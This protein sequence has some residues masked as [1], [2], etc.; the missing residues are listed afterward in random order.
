MLTYTEPFR[1]GQGRA[2]QAF[3]KYDAVSTHKMREIAGQENVPELMARL[4]RNGWKWECERV[5]MLDRDGKKCRPGVY[6]LL[7][8]H[9]EVAKKM[10]KS[11]RL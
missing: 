6:Q 3:V 9:L 8:E 4:K 10:F 11:E 5:E 7:P 2:I 1:R